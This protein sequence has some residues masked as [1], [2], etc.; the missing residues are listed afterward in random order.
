MQ[1]V[2]V[3]AHLGWWTTRG[4]NASQKRV[5]RGQHPEKSGKTVGTEGDPH[6]GSWFCRRS[7]DNVGARSWTAFHCALE[8]QISCDRCGWSQAGGLESGARQAFMELSHGLGRAQTLPTKN[9]HYCRPHSSA[10]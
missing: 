7:L 5:R 4:K 3:L 1:G 2:P 6:L 9:R 8:Q 10:Q